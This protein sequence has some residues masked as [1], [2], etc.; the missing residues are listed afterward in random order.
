MIFL[1]YS[2]KYKFQT[3]YLTALDIWLLLCML[4]VAMATFEY[5]TLLGI[6]FGKQLGLVEAIKT[7]S[8]LYQQSHLSQDGFKRQKG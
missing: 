2:P 7:M 5:A 1:K 3:R 8:L 6:K 4:F